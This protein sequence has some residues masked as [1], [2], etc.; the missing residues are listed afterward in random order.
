MRRW[1][2]SPVDPAPPPGAGP[3]PDAGGGRRPCRRLWAPAVGGRPA[4]AGTLVDAGRRRRWHR[5]A[6]GRRPR[7]ADRAGPP[8][9]PGR[10]R[11]RRR[12]TGCC[13]RPGPS[14][15]AVGGAPGRSPPGRGGGPGQRRVAPAGAG[16]RG[17]GTCA[18]RWPCVERPEQA[19]WVARA[20]GA[21]P[22]RGSRRAGPGVG[23]GGASRA[24]ARRRP[25][26]RCST[27][28]PP[29]TPAL[30]VYTSGT[31]GSPK[32]AVLTHG[33]LLAG[34][35]V[36]AGRPGAG[37]PDDRLVLALPLF[38]VHGLCAGLLGALGGG[39]VGGRARSGSTPGRCWR[40]PA[41][42]GSTLFFGVPDHVP[43]PGRRRRPGALSRLRLCVSGSAPLPAELWHEARR[44]AGVAVS[45]ATG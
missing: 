1:R 42:S 38:H 22:V 13:G 5:V 28:P 39:G 15:D 25:G 12:V 24:A 21:G 11:A 34:V 20:A 16:A 40:P 4:G 31:T 36:A 35:G 44:R 3:G 6:H 17:V 43:P 18:R 23:R 19:D 10:G 7:G 41:A 37:S 29:A 9:V 26:V 8:A 45:S 30:V 32:G 2:H 33:N 14:L 27:A